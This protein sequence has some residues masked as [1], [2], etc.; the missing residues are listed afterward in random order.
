[1]V[2]VSIF[3]GAALLLASVG[4]YGVLSYSVSV[5][6]QEISVRMAMGAPRSNILKLVIQRGLKIVG[7]RIGDRTCGRTSAESSH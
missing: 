7:Y 5:R 3:S 2:I 6:K 1:M 4:L